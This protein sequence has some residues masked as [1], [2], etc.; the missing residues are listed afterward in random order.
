MNK[1]TSIN[2]YYAV[3]II[4]IIIGMFWFVIKNGHQE[5]GVIVNQATDSTTKNDAEMS[6]TTYNNDPTAFPTPDEFNQDLTSLFK[7]KTV[8][9]LPS[10]LPPGFELMEVKTDQSTPESNAEDISLSGGYRVKY[11][12]STSRFCFI[13][14]NACDGL[15]D[16][17]GG[18]EEKTGHSDTFG[19]F[20]VQLSYPGSDGNGGE[21]NYLM[22][23]WLPNQRAIENEKQHIN[24]GCYQG[25]DFYHILGEG[26]SIADGIKII[27]SL[28]PLTDNKNE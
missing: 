24:I 17:I 11:C 9:Y 3:L 4:T 1:K 23:S 27:K 8:V 6:V 26:L 15:G 21:N 25:A 14:E 10:Y 12:N 18:D 5:V 19:Y 28:E 16:L 7:L 2:F 22:S 20:V 13:V